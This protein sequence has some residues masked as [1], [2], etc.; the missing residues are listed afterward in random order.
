[1]VASN[2]STT[3]ICVI[4]AE[5]ASQTFRHFAP[6]HSVTYVVACRVDMTRD[7]AWRKLMDANYAHLQSTSD[8][9]FIVLQ[10]LS[11]DKAAMVAQGVASQ[12]FNVKATPSFVRPASSQAGLAAATSR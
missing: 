10:E 5:E 8:T 9:V 4:D 11:D 2:N 6:L 1:M 12:V 7:E 3:R